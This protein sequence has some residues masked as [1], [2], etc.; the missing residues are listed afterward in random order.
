MPF[1]L[2]EFNVRRRMRGANAAR[3]EVYEDDNDKDFV[4]LWMSEKDI[5]ANMREFGPSPELDKALAAYRHPATNKE[6]MD[7]WLKEYDIAAVIIA[8]LAQRGG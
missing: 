8:A 4:L 6:E 1:R 7:K 3:V 2:I 5:R